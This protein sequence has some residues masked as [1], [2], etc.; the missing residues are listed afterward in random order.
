MFVNIIR[1]LNN[2]KP[3]SRVRILNTNI[4]VPEVTIV[5]VNKDNAH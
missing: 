5:N 2:T 3:A 1:F 4:V